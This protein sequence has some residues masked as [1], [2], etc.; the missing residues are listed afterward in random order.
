MASNSVPD[1]ESGTGIFRLDNHSLSSMP[2][3]ES[4]PVHEM[5][6]RSLAQLQ[7][8]KALEVMHRIGEHLLCG[9]DYRLVCAMAEDVGKTPEEVLEALEGFSPEYG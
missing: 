6:S 3:G 2:G 7:T 9:P 4:S 5:V 1:P 8:S